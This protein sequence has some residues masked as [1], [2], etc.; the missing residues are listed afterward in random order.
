MRIACKFVTFLLSHINDLNLRTHVTHNTPVQTRREQCALMTVPRHSERISLDQPVLIVLTVAKIESQTA[1]T[2]FS[3]TVG[4]RATHRRARSGQ[5]CRRRRCLQLRNRHSPQCCCCC[6]VQARSLILI[7]GFGT[8]LALDT[9]GGDTGA[10]R[11]KYPSTIA[12][13]QTRPRSSAPRPPKRRRRATLT[14]RYRMP[15]LLSTC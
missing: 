8:R 9:T 4:L 10:C 6:F 1:A 5:C 14:A 12:P 15:T 7:G 2:V 11:N 13:M 3:I